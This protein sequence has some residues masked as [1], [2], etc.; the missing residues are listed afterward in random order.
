LLA[1]DH[2]PLGA[3]SIA[4]HGHADALSVWLHWGGEAIFTGPGTYLYHAGGP[5][6]DA[7]RGTAAHN[8]LALDAQDQSRII[9]PFAWARHARCRRVNAGD[10]GVEAEHDGYRRRF[11]LIH[12][13]R[14]EARKG[15]IVI[16]DRLIGVSKR[17][18]LPWSIG[19][20]LG[21]DVA[22]EIDGGRAR[23]RTAG[24]RRLEMVAEDG[25]GAALAW[26][27]RRTPWAPSFAQLRCAPRLCLSALVGVEPLV[28]R[29]RISLGAD[30]Q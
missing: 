29:T 16:E 23:L 15:A 28:C 13:R 11:G 2:G 25:H 20:T 30:H 8:T 26:A 4:A 5:C 24:G 27:L 6:R 19:V 9:G 14:V 17:R 7:L 12:R 18:D 1:F 22:V 21:P 10:D 3:L